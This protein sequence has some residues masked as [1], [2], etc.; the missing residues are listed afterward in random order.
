M[1]TG[2]S[3]QVSLLTEALA[4]EKIDLLSLGTSDI[5][6]FQVHGREIYFLYRQSVLDSKL[7]NNVHK[8]GNT[9]TTRNWNTINKLA[10]LGG[11]DGRFHIS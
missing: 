3:I 2:E 5:D 9:V 8:L 6:E 11:T 1:S 10:A 4:Q 7:A